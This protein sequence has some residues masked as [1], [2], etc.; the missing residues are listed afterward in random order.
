M[1][2]LLHSKR[3]VSK[4]LKRA[5]ICLFMC[6]SIISCNQQ[7]SDSLPLVKPV[8]LEKIDPDLFSVEE[9]YMPYYLKHF[10]R[11]ANSVVDTGANRGYLDIIVWRNPKDNQPYNARIMES[12]LSLAWFYTTDRP[13]NPYYKDRALRK[14]I[15]ATLTFW[16]NIQNEDGRFSEYDYQRW[17]LAPTA[18]G[19]KFVGR[20]LYLLNKGPGIDKDILNRSNEALRK[21]L[22][23]TF[24]DSALWRHGKNY[25]N[26][27]ENIWSGALMYLE[28]H[29]DEEI[30]RLMIKRLEQSMTDFQSPCGYFY[31]RNGPDW[32]YNLSTHHSDLHVA[33]HYAR[34][35]AALK[36]FF[37]KK[38]ADW[39]DWFA[40]NATKE[41]GT[42]RYYLNRAVETRQQQWYFDSDAL[43]DPASARWNPIAELIPSSQ[44]FSL[45][46]EEYAAACEIYYR[47]MRDHYPN[48]RELNVGDFWAFSPYAFLHND[49]YQ[50][51]PTAKQKKDAVSKLPYL[52]RD[53]FI[54]VRKDE[55]N[56]TE[57][58][59]VRKPAYYAIFNSGK[60]ITDQQRYGLGLIWSPLLGT[61]LQ[62][63]SRTDVAA[64]GT[65]AS[66][67]KQVY[68]A[69]DITAG[70]KVNGFEWNGVAGK[71]ELEAAFFIDY[72]LSDKGSKKT[73]FQEKSIKV[74]VL[75]PGDFVEVIPLLIGEEAVLQISGNRIILEQAGSGMTISVSSS[76]IMQLPEEFSTRGG[77][78]CR[79]LEIKARGKLEYEFAFW[80]KEV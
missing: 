5:M 80:Q 62:S 37:V 3:F 38:T 26:Q 78:S 63:Q 25:T 49:L 40:Y 22:Y 16:C 11:V 13:W 21:A 7:S 46:Q 57:H 56:A 55:R 32:S 65:R 27:Y 23:V 15:E 28:H 24:T 60:I 8:D 34:Q 17:S 41:P 77:K 29:P 75:H 31:E 70:F 39:Y 61:V 66:G 2:N 74:T 71:N 20:A 76:S 64:W 51:L 10:S 48:V 59:F 12:I 43:E 67:N 44:A 45:S 6:G 69:G 47:Q 58:S 14:R 79:V 33:W 50:W 52:S 18:F 35:S 9:W 1:K 54:H 53:H 4:P 68:E 73:E 19:A 42:S 36:D 72:P 30:E